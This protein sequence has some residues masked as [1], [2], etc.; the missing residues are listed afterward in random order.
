MRLKPVSIS[1]PLEPVPFQTSGLEAAGELV[2]ASNS[3]RE[4]TPANRMN[5]S[6]TVHPVL[7]R[8][9]P[10]RFSPKAVRRRIAET[11]RRGSSPRA[12]IINAGRQAKEISMPIHD[13]SRVD[14]NLFHDF[15]QVW[16]IAIRNALNGGLLPKGYSALV[17]QHAAG[18]VPDVVALQGRTRPTP[19]AE[20]SGGAVVTATPPKTRHIIRA[21]Q[22]IAAARGN[23]ITIRH[24]LGRVVCVIEIVSPGNKASRS[25]L[26]AFIEKTVDFL[27]HGVHMLV[28]DLF[29]PSSRDP[30]GIHK[31]IWDEIEEQPFELPSDKPLTLAAYVAGIPKT[32]YV[33]PVGVGDGL[34]DMPAYLDPDSYVLVPLEATYQASWASCP[35]DMREAVERGEPLSEEP[36]ES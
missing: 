14:A 3:D 35:E 15:H 5:G 13:W 28:I 36:G 18:V 10:A 27:R 8:F 31:T 11:G 26:R 24:P 34:P 6:Q 33:E 17:E 29:P 16:T 9:R 19:R 25:A 1:L 7:T 2:A 30:Q 32:A 12:G 23:R 22:E 21:Q 20:P 4:G